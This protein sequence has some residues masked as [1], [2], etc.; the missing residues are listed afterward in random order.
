MLHDRAVRKSTG[1]TDEADRLLGPKVDAG[2]PLKTVIWAL[3][4]VAGCAHQR[5]AGWVDD[6]L[7]ATVPAAASV[8]VTTETP[9]ALRQAGWARVGWAYVASTSDG[10]DAVCADA[11]ALA[12]TH[13]GGKARR[14]DWTRQGTVSTSVSAPALQFGYVTTPSQNA[15]P[16]SYDVTHA[17]CFLEVFRPAPEVARA[18]PEERRTFDR[19]AKPCS[20]ARAAGVPCDPDRRWVASDGT[21]QSYGDACTRGD[22]AACVARGSLHYFAEEPDAAKDWYRRACVLENPLG[23]GNLAVTVKKYDWVPLPAAERTALEARAKALWNRACAQ[24]DLKACDRADPAVAYQTLIALCRAGEQ[25]HCVRAAKAS[26]D[27]AEKQALLVANC[28][29]GD[30]NACERLGFLLH[31]RD[32]AQRLPWAARGCALDGNGCSALETAFRQ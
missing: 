9:E 28:R 31:P 7:G 27:R 22:G 14:H 29:D 2:G 24:A 16:L 4:A 15:T 13:G 11:E 23:C 21:A 8:E 1:A 12:H 18:Q 30:G 26:N 17:R 25:A 5:S 19:N 20:A 6:P 10:F 32:P 3:L